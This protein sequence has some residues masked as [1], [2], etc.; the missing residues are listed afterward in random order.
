VTYYRPGTGWAPQVWKQFDAEA[1]RKDFARMK[2]LGVN[3]VRVFLSFG[4]FYRTPGELE[5]D[6]LQKFDRFLELAEAAG[7]YVHPTGPDHWE[8]PPQWSP[9]AV[10][11][12]QNV[13]ALESFWKRF[14]T[15][16]RG[17]K[18]IFAYDIKN[19]PEVGWDESMK[20]TWNEW[21]R[22]KY[23]SPE[24]LSI[25]WGDTN[26]LSFGAI[27]V[28]VPKDALKDRQLL[29]FQ[30]FREEFA[31]EWTRRQVQAIKSGDPQ[32]LVTVGFIQWSVP[33]LLPIGAR[34]YAAF[35]PDRQAK[36]L[37]FLEIHF[38]PL[39]HGAYEYRDESDELAN[40]SYLEGVVRETAR[41]GKPVVL[42]EFGWYGGA[43][44]KFDRGA[45][46]SATEAQQ[47]RYCR[48]VVETSKGFVVGWLNWGFYDQPEAGDCSELTGLVRADGTLKEWGKAFQDLSVGL[49]GKTIPSAKV[50]PRHELDWDA[51]ITS[52]K[53]GNEFRRL[54]LEDF[55]ADWRPVVERKE[56]RAARSVHLSYPAPG[57]LL[58]YNEAVVEESVNGSYFMAC[59]W[60]TGYFGIQQLDGSD[61]KV[62]LFSVWDPSKGD[63]PGAVKKEDRV[64]VLYEGEGVRIKRFG[65]EGTGGQ[66]MWKCK[67]DVGGTNR[68]VIGARVEDQKT[69][70]TAFFWA[71]GAWKK[72]ASFRVRTGG[73]PLSGYYS[74]IE[75]FRRDGKSVGETRRARFGNGWVK[76]IDGEWVPLNKARFMASGAEWESKE[77]IDSG[78]EGES[79]YLATGGDI[80]MTRELKSVIDLPTAPARP[81]QGLP[82]F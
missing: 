25:A 48:R 67:W 30:S 40:L 18:V 28:V 23:G 24:K 3:C 44:P 6:G 8:G 73:L 59:G 5:E 27:P 71:N 78:I 39:E 14:A 15:R 9:V 58:F 1:T 80:K 42:A 82:S 54:Y 74:F 20:P 33:S 45:H 57:G 56:F 36:Y 38:Y 2:A 60:N 77:N 29:D 7:I 50:G 65:G 12:E 52:S 4:S 62:V 49:Q 17:R 64:E 16:Y 55:L 66:C 70:Y 72:L 75:D 13:R 68:F 32:A 19:E 76:T 34:H 10:E 61:D 26:Q 21:L 31:D 35:R 51:C 37:D 41:P 63:D 81:P 22:K 47:A 53:A 43:K 79:F 46:P 69:A 11:N